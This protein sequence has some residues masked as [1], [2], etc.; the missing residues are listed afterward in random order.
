MKKKE[1]AA[2]TTLNLLGQILNSVPPLCWQGCEKAGPLLNA[3]GIMER[4]L[5]SISIKNTFAEI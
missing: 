1:A 2:P 5:T 3:D 4:N